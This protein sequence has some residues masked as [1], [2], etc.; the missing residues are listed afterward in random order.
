M[1]TVA[2]AGSED[3]VASPQ[4][5]WTA[6]PIVSAAINFFLLQL[7]QL[8]AW[9]TERVA[10][11]FEG[12]VQSSCVTPAAQNLAV[13]VREEEA[14]GVCETVVKDVARRPTRSSTATRAFAFAGGQQA[15]Q[16]VQCAVV[17][18]SVGFESECA[19]RYIYLLSALARR[20]T[21]C[22]AQWSAAETE[23]LC[24][25]L[26]VVTQ[27]VERI[28]VWLRA[29]NSSKGRRSTSNARPSTTCAL[30]GPPRP[31]RRPVALPAVAR[32]WNTLSRFSRLG[33]QSVG[34]RRVGCR[35]RSQQTSSPK[36]EI[37]MDVV[38]EDQSPADTS[39][40]GPLYPVAAS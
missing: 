36:P 8:G 22:Q 27:D 2:A 7:L 28:G 29:I 15:G 31:G 16:D 35:R 24:C 18:V 1:A 32:G 4:E 39:Q 23:R 37:R 34:M 19:T 40:L 21:S 12:V 26:A 33:W 11:S 14:V 38:E 13:A 9:Q 25:F 5:L 17:S 3:W 30:A 6:E 20:A 10:V